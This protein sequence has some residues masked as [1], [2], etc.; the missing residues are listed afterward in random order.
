L[1]VN[2]FARWGLELHV[3]SNGNNS[4]YVALCAKA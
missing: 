3:G 1:I 2:H 4:K